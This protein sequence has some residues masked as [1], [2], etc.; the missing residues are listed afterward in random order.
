MKKNSSIINLKNKN[1][2]L[3]LISMFMDKE[4]NITNHKR[5]NA[6]PTINLIQQD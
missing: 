3:R 5:I 1:I 4:K 2:L 6:T